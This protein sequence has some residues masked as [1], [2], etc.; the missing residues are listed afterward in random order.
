MKL[1]LRT[2]KFQSA[3]P[4]REATEDIVG[5]QAALLVSIRASRA[6]GD[7]HDDTLLACKLLFQSAPPAREAT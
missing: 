7:F 6:G 2:E 3:P 5:A 1:R 4:A